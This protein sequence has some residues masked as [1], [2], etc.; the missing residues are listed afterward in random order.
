[1]IWLLRRL[2]DRNLAESIL[3]DVEECARQRYPHSP[4]R[5]ALWMWR[6]LIGVVIAA[7]VERARGQVLSPSTMSRHEVSPRAWRWTADAWQDI[8]YAGRMCRRNPGSSL[9]AVL[10]LSLGIGC[11]TAIFSIVNVLLLQSLPYEGADRLV[12][13]SE[14]LPRDADGG[15]AGA[16]SAI[17]SADVLELRARA[18]TLSH[19]GIHRRSTHTLVGQAETVRISGA[20]VSPAIFDMLHAQP[21]LGRPFRADEEAL[22]AEPAVILSFGAWHQYFHADPEILTRHVRVD[23]E[24]VSV[25]GVMPEGFYFPDRQT[26]IWTPFALGPVVAG[27]WPVLARLQ[28]GV[29]L[30]AAHDEINSLLSSLRPQSSP[31]EGPGDGPPRFAVVHARDGLSAPVRPALIVLTIAVGLVLLIACTNVANLLLARAVG[32]ARE[33]SVRRALGAGRFRL[34]RQAL[35]ESVC[36]GVAGGIAGIVLA[37]GMIEILQIIGVGL[38]RRDL[39]PALSIPR[40]DEVRVDVFVLAVTLIVSAFSGVLFGLIPAIAQSQSNAMDLLRSDSTARFGM[41][42][43]RPIQGVLIVGQMAM[44]MA[45]LV[46][47]GLQI[48]SFAKLSSID[49]G[50]DP[51]NLLTLQVLFPDDTGPPTFADDFVTEVQRLPGVRAAGYSS[52][53]PMVQSGFISPISRT[54]GPPRHPAPG[55]SPTPEFP[56]SRSVSPGFLNALGV[57]VIAGRGLSPEGQSAGQREILVNRAFAR[58]GFLGS[59]PVGQQV[60]SSERLVEVVGVIEDVR[61]FGLDQPADPQVFALGSGGQQLYYAVKNNGSPTSQIADI[62]H[63]VH[64]LAP[65]AGLYNVATMD[66]IVASSVGRRRFYAVLMAAFAAIAASLAAVGLYGVVAYAVLRRTREIGIRVALGA[67]PRRV[68]GLIMRDAGVLI[69][70]GLLLGVAGAIALTRSFD[71]MLFDLTPLDPATYAV[72]AIFFALVTLTAAFAAA[73][74]AAS[75]DPVVALRSE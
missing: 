65:G 15:D 1:M 41:S 44:A 4:S 3:G 31:G 53:L 57:R 55:S 16:T 67:H 32:R 6:E 23:G 49:P 24:S 45:L 63:I 9:A 10:T 72:V 19:V 14:R 39:G 20:R 46:A 34:V 47:A 50:Y 18:R 37:V 61:Q 11:T 60:Y 52:S 38:T 7:I 58:T 26:E 21:L 48:H 69:V 70:T 75:A 5:A 27:R 42:G 33:I 25:V 8:G 71:A 35:T 40:L 73:R 54:P 66:Q 74:H 56:D 51:S 64:R 43:R 22:G 2:L 59:D 28:D 68:L 30:Q 62:R 36:L 17:E 12:Q 13:I 29:S